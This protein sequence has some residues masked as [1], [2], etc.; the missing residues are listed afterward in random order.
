MAAIKQTIKINAPVEKVFQYVSNYQNWPFF[1][2]GISNVKSITDET[3]ATGSKFVYKIK[4][5]GMQFPVGTEFTDFKENEGWIG[6]SFKG[7]EHRT[8]WNFRGIDG[9]TEFTHGVSYQLPWYYG[10]QLFDN[11]L[12][13]SA[14]SN[15]I[16][17][18]LQRLKRIL[19]ES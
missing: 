15:A 14:W 8:Q 7:V 5:I 2:E 1:Y 6:K 10:G 4:V 17:K 13:K 11:L 3:H 18:S 12:M 9:V 16:E 19:E